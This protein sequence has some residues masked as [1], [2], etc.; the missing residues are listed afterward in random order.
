[1]RKALTVTMV[2]L[3]ASCGAPEERQAS[4]DLKTFDSTAEYAPAEATDA[5]TSG[6]A[7]PAPPGVSPTAAPGVAF[8]YRYAFRLPA[9]AIGPVQEQHAAACEKLGTDRCRIT[10]MRYT[11][12]DEEGNDI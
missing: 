8:N 11:M 1:M 4:E 10:G 12:S 2:L 9:R 3:L 6:R 7:P 5:A